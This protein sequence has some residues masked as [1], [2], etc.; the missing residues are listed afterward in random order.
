MKLIEIFMENKK[1][2]DNIELL[3]K[4]IDTQN[5]LASAELDLIAFMQ[6]LVNKIHAF[7]SATGTVVELVEGDF[8]VYKAVS[9]T[10]SNYYELKLPIKNS[11]SGLCVLENRVLISEDTEID[12]RVNLEACRKVSAR[13]MVV[14][15][16]VFSG[17]PVGVI[18]ILSKYPNA[19][20]EFHVK[21]LEIM[22]GFIASG[23]KHQ[24]LFQEKEK[25]IKKLKV[26][27]KHL[28]DMTKH[29]YLTKLPNRKFFNTTLNYA[30][31]KLKRKKGL[32]AL[33]FLDIDHFK[34]VNDN[35]GHDKGD[36]LLV[37]FAGILEKNVRE[38]DLVV[39]LGGDE[40][41]ILLDDLHKRDDAT[42]VAKKIINGIHDCPFF[43]KGDVQI[44]TS[45]GISFYAGEKTSAKELIKQA[46]EA[47]YVVKLEGRDNYKIFK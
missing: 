1:S 28:S 19:F 39:R 20:N 30:M 16:L 40:F 37:K 10:V 2:I 31:K 22:A 23:L 43:K 13:S 12:P 9:G 27:Q 21:I 36:E 44:T 6:L 3:K 18:K 15:P 5:L 25:A 45:I 47:L 41:V 42:N 46:D 26:T 24:L 32:I 33:M 8:M 14:A 7:V 35:L 11:I 34:W 29:D 17:K 38:Y 4:I